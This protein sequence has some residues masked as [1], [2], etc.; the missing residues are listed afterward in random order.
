MIDLFS[1]GFSSSL[2]AVQ[3]LLMPA[4]FFLLIGLAVKKAKL[5]TD[6]KKSAKESTL[7][8]K[9]FLFDSFAMSPVIILVS[10][11]VNSFFQWHGWTL[12]SQ[13]SWSELPKEIVI[14]IAVFAGDFIGYWRHRLEHTWILWPSHAVHHSDTQMT[15]FTLQRFH[16]VN[17]ITT[18]AIDSAFLLALGLPPFAVIANGFVRHYYGYFIHAD[19]PWT[20]GWLGRI[21]VSPA[22]HRW[23]HAADYRFF[24]TNFATVFSV[25]DQ[26]FGT[27]K[28]PG[29]CDS[30][31][32]VTDQIE[33]S[34]IGQ[35]GYMFRKKSY[36]RARK[37]R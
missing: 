37:P 29:P 15:W 8:V 32:G 21:F 23:H 16:P 5:I 17:R 22:M 11:T 2:T 25:F 36:R 6:V 28:V 7:N 19:L 26:V 3:G 27:H 9:I 1:F 4:L 10:L 30:K 20:Y 33:A 31:L 34:L 35:L 24:Q 14:V 18:T 13:E 12:V